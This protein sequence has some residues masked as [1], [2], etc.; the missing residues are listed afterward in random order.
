MRHP[1]N[2]LLIFFIVL[3]YFSSSTRHTLYTLA[4][5]P[6]LVNRCDANILKEAF[7]EWGLRCCFREIHRRN[8]LFS[9][10]LLNAT[11]FVLSGKQGFLLIRLSAVLRSVVLFFLYFNA[12]MFYSICYF[13]LHVWCL[14]LV[15]LL[16]SCAVSHFGC[17]WIP[18]FVVIIMIPW[19][20]KP[21]AI[22][23]LYG[24]TGFKKN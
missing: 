14:H 18:I 4:G 6:S 21:W 20:H 3:Y 24:M 5:C 11:I 7:H 15:H 13:C 1:S 19:C 22:R 9:F 8:L 12:F 23:A 10:T 17:V 2:N 16:V